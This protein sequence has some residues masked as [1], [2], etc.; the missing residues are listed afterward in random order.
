M[1]SVEVGEWSERS[2]PPGAVVVGYNGKTHSRAALRWAAEEAVVRDAPLLVLYAANYL[3]MTVEPGPGL[4]HREPGALEAAYEVTARGSAK[5]VS[6]TRDSP[7]S[8]PPR[9][10]APP[11]L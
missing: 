2:Y 1:A 8:V 3:G 6:S 10:P 5:P 9:S 11:R 7:W 4:H